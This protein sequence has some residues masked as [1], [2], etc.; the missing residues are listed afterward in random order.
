M[1]T[2]YSKELDARLAA[3][4][5][6]IAAVRRMLREERTC[7]DVLMQLSAAESALDRVAKLMLKDHLNHCVRE[8]IQRGETDSLESFGRILDK[9]IK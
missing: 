9:Y 4:E 6:Q 1:S 8:S 3:A 5:G 7:E 2:H